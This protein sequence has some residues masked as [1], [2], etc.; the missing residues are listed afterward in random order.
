MPDI[1]EVFHMA[2]QK[3]RPDP[4]ALE[5]QHSDQRKLVVR[6]KATVF[7]LIGAV[8]LGAVVFGISVL[9]GDDT[10]TK[11]GTDP[12]PTASPIPAP[13]GPLEPGTYA[14][15]TVPDFD[16]SY[17]V[18]IDVPESY[19]GVG[20]G[21]LK[22]GRSETSVSAWIIGDVYADPCD[23]DSLVDRSTIASPEGV[24]TALASQQGLRVSTRTDVTLA[25][26]TGTYMERTLRPSAVDRCGPG[27]LAMWL[28]TTGDQRF[29]THAGQHDLLWILDV[30]GH[31]LVI[32]ASVDADGSAE[33]RA[34]V[35]AM[36][37]SIQ[38]EPR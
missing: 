22:N 33:D 28:D 26:F 27:V 21:V 10:T 29:L 23:G 11:L 17:Q 20:F 32:D 7:A 2:T 6:Q 14:L 18:T 3:V 36:V 13:T 9:Q 35:E 25:G 38:I 5:R 30:D 31:T 1:Q 8:V 24:A 34:E 4:N 15:D 16:A 19:R 37:D 12:G